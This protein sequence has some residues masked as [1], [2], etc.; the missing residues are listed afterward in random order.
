[1]SISSTVENF[2]DPV[3]L[4]MIRRVMPNIIAQSIIGVQPMTGPAGSI[5][6]MRPYGWPGRVLFTKD[7]YRHF[8]R[9]YNRRK[10]HHP[11]YIT[12][13]GYSKMRLS[14]RD[15]LANNAEVWCRDNLK[16]GS[17]VYDRGDFWFAYERDYTLFVLKWS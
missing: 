11:D 13:L 17:Y 9:V 8:L 16:T 12:G 4:P 14:R 15:H 2:F 10:Y 1:M 3:L 7:H 6:S 5:F